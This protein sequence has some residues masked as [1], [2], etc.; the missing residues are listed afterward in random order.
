MDELTAICRGCDLPVV[1]PST[2]LA[3]QDAQPLV[4][5]KDRPAL[6][7]IHDDRL[8]GARSC[9]RLLLLLRLRLLRLRLLRLL[10]LLLARQ[11]QGQGQG[12]LQGL[13]LGLCSSQHLGPGFAS[14]GL[15]AALV[16]KPHLLQLLLH[17]QEVQRTCWRFAKGHEQGGVHLVRRGMRMLKRI[18]LHRG[19]VA[20]HLQLPL[21]G[22]DGEARVVVGVALHTLP[23]ATTRAPAAIAACTSAR[24]CAPGWSRRRHLEWHAR[25]QHGRGHGQGHARHALQRLLG[26]LELLRVGLR[27]ILQ[28][29]RLLRRKLHLGLQLLLL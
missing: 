16:G 14:Q 24:P 4:G 20:E 8:T 18:P 15:A 29:L 25:P 3:A 7:V 13:Q 23:A 9:R 10:R 2:G 6:R 1:C 12:R 21:Q 27:R 19:T 28:L 5:L 26:Q 22:Q 17:H 11:G